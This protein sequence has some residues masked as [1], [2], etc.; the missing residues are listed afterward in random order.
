MAARRKEGEAEQPSFEA[1]YGQLE[2]TARRLEQGNLPLDESL[3]L[4][5]SGA[6]LVDQLRTILES[7]D[8]RIRT[9]QHRYA[10]ERAELGEEEPEYDLEGGE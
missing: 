1:L 10:E 3:A 8:L 6:A 2:E 4:Y 5:E 9:V 7:A